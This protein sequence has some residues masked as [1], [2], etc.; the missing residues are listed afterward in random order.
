MTGI[1]VLSIKFDISY[2]PIK[3]ILKKT[4]IRQQNVMPIRLIL[5]KIKESL[6]F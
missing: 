4:E 5:Y 3:K 2:S 1:L 6:L